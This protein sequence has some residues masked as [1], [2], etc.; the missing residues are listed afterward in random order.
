MPCC[1]SVTLLAAGKLEA[2][3]DTSKQFDLAVAGRALIPQTE[4]KKSEESLWRNVGFVDLLCL[5]LCCLMPSIKSLTPTD[6][7]RLSRALYLSDV[8]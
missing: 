1:C 5:M 2:L 3:S 7:S 6:G 4:E 8:S